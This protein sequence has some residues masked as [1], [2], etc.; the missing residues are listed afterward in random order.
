MMVLISVCCFGTVM[1]IQL[2]VGTALLRLA[3]GPLT[4]GWLL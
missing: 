4:P 1:V 2:L 3:L